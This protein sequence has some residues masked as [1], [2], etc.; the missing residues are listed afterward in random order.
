MVRRL[1]YL[2]AFPS[3]LDTFHIANPKLLAPHMRELRRD[4]NEF[5]WKTEHPERPA[6]LL[7]LECEQW[8]HELNGERFEVALFLPEEMSE[9]DG[10]V[11]FRVHAANLS[12]AAALRIPV[13]VAAQPGATFDA[14]RAAVEQLI[15]G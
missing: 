10:L 12:T 15:A 6:T 14:A 7:S 3:A 8:R 13:R 9:A 4:P 2:S 5:Y 11:E 1:D